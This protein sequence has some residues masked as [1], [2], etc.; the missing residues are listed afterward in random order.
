MTDEA[1]DILRAW[2]GDPQT[3]PTDAGK[4]SKKATRVIEATRGTMHIVRALRWTDG[5]CKPDMK[6]PSGRYG[7]TTIHGWDY[8]SFTGKV[9][10]MWSKASRHG[11]GDAP[12]PFGG[13]S[14]RGRDLYSTK[15]RA[16]RALRR[17]IEIDCAR[18]LAKIDE[19][20]REEGG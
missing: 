3:L 14:Q 10:R 11:Q 15:L 6:K 2:N 7:P 13:G 16:L 4:T 12:S 5:E 1:Y 19:Q 20:I 9:Y 18:K 17:A 8:N